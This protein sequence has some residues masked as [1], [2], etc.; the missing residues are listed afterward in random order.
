MA[1]AT[2]LRMLDMFSGTGS[3][4]AVYRDHGFEVTTLD[5]FWTAS[6][7]LRI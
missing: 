4:G 3:V 6:P 5:A 1:T 7:S 2:P